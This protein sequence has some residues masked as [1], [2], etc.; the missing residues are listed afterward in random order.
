M[1]KHVYRRNCSGSKPSVAQHMVK[2]CSSASPRSPFVRRSTAPFGADRTRRLFIHN[3]GELNAR[4]LGYI[5][6]ARDSLQKTPLVVFLSLR[7]GA[8]CSRV[9][10]S[11]SYTTALHS[12]T[13]S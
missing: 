6:R 9:C 8:L 10:Q 1:A 7:E 5:I 13:A 2:Q 11:G 4:R 12:S 3:K